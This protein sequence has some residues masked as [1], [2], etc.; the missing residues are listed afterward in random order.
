MINYT[1]NNM[2]VNHQMLTMT[3]TMSMIII[4]E[5]EPEAAA[6]HTAFAGAPSHAAEIRL[7]L[8][9]NRARRDYPTR[10]RRRRGRT[11]PPLGRVRA[12]AIRR[13]LLGAPLLNDAAERRVE[14][15]SGVGG[16]AGDEV[17]VARPNI[18][19]HLRRG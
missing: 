12:V 4:T 10:R 9:T 18:V 19:E 1:G 6:R 17:A 11:P 14:L 16:D 15:R 5:R 8:R 3:L 7:A 13:E 2:L